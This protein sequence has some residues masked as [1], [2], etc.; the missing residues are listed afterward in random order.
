MDEATLGAALDWLAMIRQPDQTLEL[1][2]HGGE[3]LLAGV[4]WYRHA[5]PRIRTRFQTGLRLSIQSNL[6][7]LDDAFCDLIE[8][9]DIGLGTSLDGPQPIN[10]AQR[11]QGSFAKTMRGIQIARS[12]GISVGII[13]TF[14]HRSADRWQEVFDFFLSEGLSFS[15]HGAI[16]T[17]DEGADQPFALT[18]DGYARLFT[19][20]FDYYLTKIRHI[21]VATFDELAR[22]LTGHCT[23]CTF[24]P[25]LGR[26]LSISSDGGIYPCNRFAA[27]SAWRLGAVQD[28]PTF[29]D[30]AGTAAWQRLQER[31]ASVRQDC[32]DCAWFSN[33]SGGCAYH[34]LAAGTD[35]RD[36]Y[37][38]AYQRIFAHVTDRVLNQVFSAD[39]LAAVV[40]E[41]SS[42]QRGL[43]R[44]GELLQV[45]G[46]GP[47]PSST[48][49]R[50]REAAAAV[51]LAVCGSPAAAFGTLEQVGLI[52]HP[53]GARV[54]LERLWQRLRRL[55]QNRS[56]AYVHV[57]YACNLTCSHCYAT[58]GPAR[59]AESMS[60][61]QVQAV[62][63]SLIEH[64]FQRIKITGGEPLMHPH[65]TEI[66]DLLISLRSARSD[67]QVVLR[68]NLSLPL[69]AA[70]LVRLVD[71][72]DH[73]IV[74]IDGDQESHDARR[75]AGAYAR[76]VKNLRN[77]VQVCGA[78]PVSLAATVTNEQ[79]HGQPGRSAR[80]LGAELN[81]EVRFRPLLP[82]G[83]G[84]GLS[85]PT[86]AGLPTSTG[87]DV[88]NSFHARNSCSLGQN[89]HLEVNG[90]CYPCFALLGEEH[91]LGNIFEQGLGPIMDRNARYSQ[92]TVDT[93]RQCCDCVWRY[94]CGGSCRMGNSG[95]GPNEPPLDCAA[96][97]RR[98]AL[99]LSHAL[100][101]LGVDRHV[102]RGAGLPEGGDR[103]SR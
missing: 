99:V 52:T 59:S 53:Q 54:S 63:A 72:V 7:L 90:D 18:A 86:G 42:D 82:L 70:D 91:K 95:E 29:A 41:G 61:A 33:C 67:S 10:D 47:H 81:C 34:A 66:Q 76:T 77:L 46:G 24:A 2:L 102:W 31:E 32:D 5:L 3:P 15:F 38:Q 16:P 51:A 28:R 45:M 68:T 101:V 64:S 57:T 37:C 73:I 50:A 23:A 103:T 11:G 30:L 8:E 20:M 25:C 89:L 58:G 13:C 19:A 4:A 27:H 22:G 65:W 62:L 92:C 55:P 97:E 84:R 44:R 39:N 48:V 26:Y 98:S 36:G 93:N 9:Y 17:L 79:A 60:V 14:T 78:I 94:L 83:R 6:W 1:V 80:A 40:A 35:R 56:E 21:R 74:S 71:C 75:G 43:L 85:L 12:R 87:I 69:S 96:L 100:D 88:L 49:I